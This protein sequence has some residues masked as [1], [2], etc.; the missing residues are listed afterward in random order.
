MR[1]T[2]NTIY[3]QINTDLSRLT[4]NMAKTTRSIS[5][6]K[7]YSTLSDSPVA[8]TE[9]LGIRDVI[10]ST[11]QY[12]DNITYGQGWVTATDSAMSQIQDRLTRAKTLAV[13]GA[14]DTQDA[15]SRKAIAEEVKS[16]IDEVVALGNTKMGDRYVFGGTKT[17]GYATGEAPFV[18]QADGTVKYNGN[19][20]DIAIQAASGLRQK[21]NLDGHTALVEG[22]VFNSL[23]VLYNGLMS[24]NQADI[25]AAISDIDRAIGYVNQ[26]SATL[27]AM[28]NALTNK[29]SMADNLVLTNTE[30]LSS[31]EDTDIV[32][33]VTDLT[34]QQTSYQAALAAAA[35][36]MNVSL[37]DYLK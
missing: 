24:D 8:L 10:S 11:N 7:I 4:D 27:G 35:K 9:A 25:I 17:T 3:D 18:L 12:K 5:S 37:V 16:I 29:S 14:N 28:S 31:V 21:I 20:E 2:M 22:G 32:K 36:V 13:Q 23:N 30:R 19:Q 15:N 1:I 34:T 33:A 26:Q 6:G